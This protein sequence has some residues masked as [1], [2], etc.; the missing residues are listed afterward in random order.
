M[1]RAT[2]PRGRARI[3]NLSD[4]SGYF[5]FFRPGNAELLVKI[6]DGRTVNGY[7]WIFYGG[8]TDLEYTLTVNDVEGRALWSY[9]NP[10]YAL[11]SGADT[12]AL[13]G[14]P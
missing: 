2:A 5:W 8:L 7:F 12:T 10:P 6:L 13:T 4:E 1:T 14:V 11:T 9:H 3:E